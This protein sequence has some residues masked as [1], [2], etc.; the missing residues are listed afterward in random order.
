MLKTIVTLSLLLLLP[1][2]FYGQ[3]LSGVWTGTLSND[4]QT[5]RRQQ[6]FELALTEYKGK[7]Y[8]YSRTE[9]VVNDT[10]YYVVKRVKGA[11][12]DSIAEVTDEK[13][14]TSNFP[15]KIDKNVKVTTVFRLNKVDSSWRMDGTWK[16]NKTR[17]Y[18]SITGSLALAADPD[19]AHSRIMAHLQELGQGKDMV[20]ANTKPIT[21]QPAKTK[22]A[23]VKKQPA[24]QP[25]AS[26]PAERV[27]VVTQT[28]TFTSDSL[29]L[30]LY[31]NG[32]IDGDTVS[33][34]LNN[35]VILSK[36]LLKQTAIRHTVHIPPSEKEVQLVLYAENLGRYPPNTGLLIIRDGNKEY[37]VRY[38]ADLQSNAAIVLKREER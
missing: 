10:L 29:Q 26:T 3:H 28:I 38:S 19:P 33:V 17:N 32:E 14:L 2:C 15:H 11:V 7:I 21:P 20:F 18:Y 9:F 5:V 27:T 25:V 31:D 34:L 24:P 16:T 36:Q 6:Q 1:V 35:Q 30:A 4:S 23:T 13:I 12:G 8:G 22:P 37:S